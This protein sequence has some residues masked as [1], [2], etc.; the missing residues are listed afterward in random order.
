M[1]AKYAINE[2]FYS[3]QGEGVRAGTANVFVRFQGC[4]LR[5]SKDDE[6]SQFECDTEWSSGSLMT[7]EDIEKSV[8]LCQGKVKYEYSAAVVA[9]L[10]SEFGVEADATAILS[11][12]RA[13]MKDVNCNWLILTGGEP[14]LQVDRE[15][16]DYFHSRGYKLAIETN[17]TIELPMSIIAVEDDHGN[18]YELD[19]IQ[20]QLDCYHLDWITVS[21]KSA[22]HTIK[23][24]VAHEVK[25]VRNAGQ[26]IPK[27]S[28]KALNHVLSPAFEAGVQQP[29]G[30][31]L[32]RTSSGAVDQC[33]KL[34]LAHPEWRMCPQTHKMWRVR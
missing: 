13:E 24:P 19:P 27:P 34:C 9:E 30:T 6:F 25:Y 3:L 7:L 1:S 14:A 33:I 4:N 23:Q 5:C 22:E 31:V 2:I 12:I 16:C 10:E 21:P 29:D 26:A 8:L 17:G 32:H 11:A 18:P 20:R 15:F 28:C